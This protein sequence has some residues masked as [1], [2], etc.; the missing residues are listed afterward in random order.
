MTPEQA[1]AADAAC[2]DMHILLTDVAD[3]APVRA[4]RPCSTWRAS[5]SHRPAR[6]R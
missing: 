1:E 3:A 4:A 5:N 6:C 2:R